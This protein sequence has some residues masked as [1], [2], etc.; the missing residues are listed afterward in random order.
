M[1]PDV[2]RP[3]PRPRAALF[4]LLHQE[5]EIAP[6]R[7]ILADDDVL[8]ILLVAVILLIHAQVEEPGPVE[9]PDHLRDQIAADGIVGV[10]RDAARVLAQ[11]GVVRGREIQLRDRLQAER[12]QP[13]QLTPQFGGAP[14]AFDRNLRV[15]LIL[16][17]VAQVDHHHV[18]A[19]L[20]H[21][22]EQV[23]PQAPVEAEFRTGRWS[24]RP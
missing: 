4:D 3:D 10:G 24:R 16:H 22:L 5:Q 6:P 20:L 13:L 21:L 18:H 19:R 8:V 17:P 11:P 1:V 2:I 23:V 14:G 9:Q 7:V 15:A 12:P